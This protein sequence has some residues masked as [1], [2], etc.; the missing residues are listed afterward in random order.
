MDPEVYI[1]EE[2]G[3]FLVRVSEEVQNTSLRLDAPPTGST[4]TQSA[5]FEHWLRQFRQLA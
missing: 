2:K 4:S 1:G 3:V 5:R